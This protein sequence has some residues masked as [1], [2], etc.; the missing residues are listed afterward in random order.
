MFS[1]V[2]TEDITEENYVYGQ[3]YSVE[4]RSMNADEIFSLVTDFIEIIGEFE[5]SSI[6]REGVFTTDLFPSLLSSSRHK[7]GMMYSVTVPST[8]WVHILACLGAGITY[9]NF[10][11]EL[12]SMIDRG[13]NR[14]NP[15]L[16]FIKSVY[17]MA[18]QVYSPFTIKKTRKGEVVH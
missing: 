11:D 7:N 3:D 10:E 6:D 17:T 2:S 15:L 9:T 14:A 8:R 1:I 5:V 4:I 12:K 13:E 16:I 18:A